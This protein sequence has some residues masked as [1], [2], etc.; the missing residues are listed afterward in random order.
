[1]GESESFDRETLAHGRAT[2]AGDCVAVAGTLGAGPADPEPAG[3]CAEHEGGEPTTFGS[4]AAAG[5]D[6]RAFLD[7]VAR[8]R[9]RFGLQ[10]LH[11]CLMNNHFHLLVKLRDPPEASALMAGL[12]RAYV[13][14]Y[15]LRHGF[16]GHRWQGRFKSPAVQCRDYLLSC[17]RYT[18]RNPL[19]AG[20]VA[21]PWDYPWSSA[22]VR[23]KEVANSMVT[24]SAEYHE[25]ASEPDVRQQW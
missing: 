3:L 21:E 25:L 5:E 1:M 4:G 12:L 15:H 19:E 8:Y 24:E 14:Q 2:V 17:G 6:R 20:A 13:H 11:Y 22:P 23:A 10:L 9:D 7:S 16:L 18:E